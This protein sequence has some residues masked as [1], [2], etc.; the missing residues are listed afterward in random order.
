MHLVYVDESGNTGNNLLDQNQ[1]ILVMSA[2]VV[3]EDRWQALEGALRS[4]I[5]SFF[6]THVPEAFE[7]HAADLRSGSKHFRGVPVDDRI[8]LRNE[9]MDLA[10]AFGLK[11][12]YRAINKLRYKRW[13][14][15]TCGAGLTINPCIPAYL[16]VANVVN[17]YLFSI[18]VEERGILVIDENKEVAKDVEKALRNL[19]WIPHPI[20]LTQMIERGFFI[21]SHTSLPLQLCDLFAL[22]ARRMEEAKIGRQISDGDRSAIPY[23]EAIL[24]KGEGKFDVVDWLVDQ[25]QK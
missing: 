22:W 12:V 21:E 8:R 10:R 5:E 3:P 6:K 7:L 23:I 14:D 17:D 15:K 19:R 13:H 1:P 2:L 11:F 24:H 20:A 16:L 25:M 4:L 9:C 18:G